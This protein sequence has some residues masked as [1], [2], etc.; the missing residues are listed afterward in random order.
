[1]TSGAEVVT[2]LASSITTQA[3]TAIPL[4]LALI[5]VSLAIFLGIKFYGWARRALK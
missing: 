5:G 2:A 3:N 4:V 1:M